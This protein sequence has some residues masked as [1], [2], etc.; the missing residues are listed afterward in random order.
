MFAR[1]PTIIATLIPAST[2]GLISA[3]TQSGTQRLS[4]DSFVL[5]RGRAGQFEIGMTVDE[6]YQL[7]GREHVCVVTSFRGA[8]ARPGVE[9]QV[10]GFTAGAALTRSVD[11][12]CGPLALWGI[13]V[14]DARFRTSNGL[15]VGSTLGDVKRLYRRAKVTGID[16]DVEPTS[17]SRA[18]Q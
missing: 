8:E 5:E 11:P 13:E 7:V 3:V 18:N 1:T 15:G 10:P 6:L 16:T 4:Q 2:T 14:H 9:I 12:V 17:R